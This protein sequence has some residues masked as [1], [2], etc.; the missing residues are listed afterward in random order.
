VDRIVDRST[1][2]SVNSLIYASIL[3]ETLSA[4]LSSQTRTNAG[5]AK[6]DEAL[7]PTFVPFSVA[8]T[9]TSAPFGFGPRSQG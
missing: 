5:I 4:T 3:A 6:S 7:A 8:K 9:G 1:E 2:Q